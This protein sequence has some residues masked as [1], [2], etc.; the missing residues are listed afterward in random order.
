M[1]NFRFRSAL[2]AATGAR[3]VQ[4]DGRKYLSYVSRCISLQS[5]ANFVNGQKSHPRSSAVA[6]RQYSRTPRHL[7]TGC[8]ALARLHSDAPAAHRVRLDR[9]GTSFICPGSKNTCGARRER[10]DARARNPGQLV[11]HARRDRLRLLTRRRWPR[12]V[13]LLLR[14]VELCDLPGE[15]AG[16]RRA[17][18]APGAGARTGGARRKH[19]G[20]QDGNAAS[21]SSTTSNA[22]TPAPTFETAEERQRRQRW[23]RGRRW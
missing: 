22:P 6:M 3:R 15:R 21:Q 10:Q 16:A 20:E 23:Q 5:L 9:G 14:L 4:R 12:R 18:C 1:H 2:R 13:A 17:P 19:R 7:A 8:R 11:A